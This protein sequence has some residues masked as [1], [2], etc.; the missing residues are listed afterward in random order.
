[1]KRGVMLLKKYAKKASDM[2]KKK[3]MLATATGMLY[4]Y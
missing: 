3:R 1:M 2:N 4:M